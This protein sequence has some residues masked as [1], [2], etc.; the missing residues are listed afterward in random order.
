M[1]SHLY[2]V[3][4]PDGEVKEFAANILAGNCMLQVDS[5]GHHSQLLD[6]ITDV[7]C[8]DRDIAKADGYN[9]TKRGQRKRRET[10]VGWHLDTKWK[11]G[12]KQWVP[13]RL[14]NE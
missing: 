13:L 12:K 5:N 4:F 7:R 1:N 3:E 6:C 2:K 8:D 10:K 9:T 14:I 11:N